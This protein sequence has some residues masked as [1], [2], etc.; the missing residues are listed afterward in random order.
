MTVETVIV[1]A[2]GRDFVNWEVVHVS[3]SIREAARSFQVTA[4]AVGGLAA[5]ATL[6]PNGTAVD[7][8]AGSDLLCRG[9][10]DR[11]R[12]VLSPDR[13]EVV[14]HGRS[15]AQDVVD[16]SAMHETGRFENVTVKDVATAL[17]RF[18]VGFVT[19]ETLGK[20]GKVQVHPGESVFGCLSRLCASQELTMAG[21]AD[22]SIRFYRAG[23]AKKHAG[24]LIEG[25][26]LQHGEADHDFR[27]R[28][29]KHHVRGQR[30]LGMGVDALEVEAVASDATVKRH[31]PLITVIQDDIDHAGATR[32]A[33]GRR[34]R[35]AGRGLTAS[36][37]VV[38]WRDPSG[39]VWTPGWKVW[40]ESP[41]LGLA[42]DMLIETASFSQS[43]G[44]GAATKTVLHL[45]DP[46]AYGGKK[47]KG[48]KSKPAW[49]MDESNVE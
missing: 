27:Q 12:P 32:R 29:S 48:N 49:D 43:G 44:E 36:I 15:R 17:D 16:C 22:G 38:G 47:G 2:G 39:T 25:Q 35:S 24:G 42:Q 13:G 20:I 10:V 28:H 18:G 6:L 1:R 9:Y 11:R 21:E 34:D 14:I 37:T 41:F 8:L 33:R 30:P 46:R 5:L 7:I 3:A 4:A 40:V 19:D 26:N 23:R 31:R 45:V